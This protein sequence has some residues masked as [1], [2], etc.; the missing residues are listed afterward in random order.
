MSNYFAEEFNFLKTS[1]YELNNFDV[2]LGHMFLDAYKVNILHIWGKLKVHAKSG[3][4]L[5][6]LYVDYNFTLEEM[7]VNLV[8]LASELELPNFSI[9]MPLKVS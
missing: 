9:L 2:I 6:N 1:P 3:S 7:G 8:A 4:K 5:V